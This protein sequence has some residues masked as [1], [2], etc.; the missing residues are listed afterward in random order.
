MSAEERAGVLAQ[1]LRLAEGR[2]G[3]DPCNQGSES[4]NELARS[5]ARF[6][7]MIVD[8]PVRWNIPSTVS[9]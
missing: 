6:D 9:I 4:A 3:F 1:I 2:I 8:L 5:L 7:G